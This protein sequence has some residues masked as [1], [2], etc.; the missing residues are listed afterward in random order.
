MYK[1]PVKSLEIF[2]F[3]SFLQSAVLLLWSQ[4]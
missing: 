3:L 1:L 2:L 4:E